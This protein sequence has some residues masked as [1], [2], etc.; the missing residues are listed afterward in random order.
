MQFKN[1]KTHALLSLHSID[2]PAIATGVD[3]DRAGE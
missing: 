3:L 2:A 1:F